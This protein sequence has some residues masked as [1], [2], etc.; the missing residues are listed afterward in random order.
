MKT[1]LRHIV[2]TIV[3]VTAV[4]FAISRMSEAG[5]IYNIS[6]WWIPTLTTIEEEPFTG[7]LE[8]TNTVTETAVLNLEYGTTTKKVGLDLNYLING[9]YDLRLYSGDNG[10]TPLTLTAMDY[11]GLAGDMFDPDGMDLGGGWSSWTIGSHD[12]GLG[13]ILSMDPVVADANE[14]AAMALAAVGFVVVLGM[15]RSMVCT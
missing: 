4:L 2:L 5:T 14:P 6:G 10:G 1:T 3:L 12:M 11:K 13:T 15:M 8:W 7:T 9:A